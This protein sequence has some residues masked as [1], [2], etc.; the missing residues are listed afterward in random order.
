MLEKQR[1][2]NIILVKMNF[3]DYSFAHDWFWEELSEEFQ[4]LLQIVTYSWPRRNHNQLYNCEP[5]PITKKIL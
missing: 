4:I 5:F 1:T 3:S 2:G